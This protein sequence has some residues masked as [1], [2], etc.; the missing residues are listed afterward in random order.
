MGEPQSLA[1]HLFDVVSI[2]VL[3]TVYVVSLSVLTV[4]GILRSAL[5]RLGGAAG[6]RRAGTGGQELPVQK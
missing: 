1:R 4:V 5:G 3:G 6:E 2:L